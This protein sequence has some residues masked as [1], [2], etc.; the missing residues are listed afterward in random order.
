MQFPGD[1]R[2]GASQVINCRC[3][4]GWRRIEEE[5]PAPPPPQA[6]IPTPIIPEDVKPTGFGISKEVTDSLDKVFKWYKANGIKVPK[7]D[8]K[9]LKLL[10]IPPKGNN[11]KGD[12]FGINNVTHKGA[13]S[14]YSDFSGTL[15]ITAPRRIR[16][17]TFE[18]ERLLYHE[19]GHAIHN[20]QNIIRDYWHGKTPDN[21]FKK[22]FFELRAKGY[23]NGRTKVQREAF[24]KIKSEYRVN[25]NKF[26][27]AQRKWFNGEAEKYASE[28]AFYEKE[29]GLKKGSLEGM[30]HYDVSSLFTEYADTIQALSDA[31]IGFGHGKSYMKKEYFAQAEFFAHCMEV[32]FSGNPIFEQ[33]DK[34][35]FDKM[36]KATNELLEQNGI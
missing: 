36:V 31:E 24:Q 8:E 16:R 17:T 27:Q 30:N 5:T 14:S 26:N 15:N 3:A 2:G 35:L 4:L 1:R 28:G 10:S 7:L 6:N 25:E 22:L 20:R 11:I 21:N 34:S 23:K 32:R 12:L 29:L 18:N 9:F 33:L 13:T 19:Y